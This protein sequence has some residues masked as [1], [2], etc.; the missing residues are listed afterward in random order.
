MALMLL[1]TGV[2]LAGIVHSGFNRQMDPKGC[3]MTFMQPSYYRLLGLGPEQTKLASKYSLLLYR[4]EYDY[5]PRVEHGQLI[6]TCDHEWSI[7]KD[8]KL[9]PTG[10]PALFIPGNA[11][12]AKQVRSMAKEASKYYYQ[13]LRGGNL[14]SVKPID[15]NEEFTAFHGKS[16]WD[17]A[18]YVNEAIAYILSLYSED[19][20]DS[21]R[22][23]SI[24]LIGHSMGGIVARTI[25]TLDNFQH[26]SV[27]TIV[28][29]ATPHAVPPVALD[30]ETTHIYDTIT[31]FW[32]RGY[33]GEGAMLRNVTLV[34]I[35]GGTLDTTVN[36]DSANIHSIIPQSHGFTVFTSNIPHVWVGCDH[37]SILWCNQVASAIGQTL[38][39]VAEA[40]YSGKSAS[41]AERMA[42][43]RRRLLTGAEKKKSEGYDTLTALTDHG[44]GEQSRLDLLLCKDTAEENPKRKT[45]FCSSGDLPI[46]PVPASTDTSSMPLFTGECFTAREFRSMSLSLAKVQDYQFLAI[47]DRGRRF[48]DAGFLIAQ[49]VNMSMT[50]KTVETSM[51]DHLTTGIRVNLSTL[52]SLTST[53]RLPNIDN[54]LF[55]YTLSV[56]KKQCR[57]QGKR[58]I[59]LHF[60]TDPSCPEPLSLDLHVDV[61]GSLGRVLIR[62]RMVVLVFTYMVVVLTVQSQFWNW[63]QDGTFQSFGITLRRLITSPRS[64]KMSSALAVMAFIQ[65]LQPKANIDLGSGNQ[66][67]AD[68]W[69]SWTSDWRN[70]ILRDVPLGRNATFFWFLAPLFFQMAV[71]I[72]VLIWLVLNTLVKLLAG[73]LALTMRSCRAK[74]SGVLTPKRSVKSMVVSI[75]VQFAFVAIELPHHLAFVAIVVRIL[76]LCAK[77]LNIAKGLSTSSSGTHSQRVASWNRFHYMSSVLVL[78]FILVPFAVP[79]IMALARNFL[80]QWHE[81]FSA[82][83]LVYHVA[84]FMILV[85]NLARGATISASRRLST[86]SLLT[87]QLF[88]LANPPNKRLNFNFVS[89]SQPKLESESEATS[90]S[91]IF[92]EPGLLQPRP[93]APPADDSA[94]IKFHQSSSSF[95]FQGDKAIGYYPQQQ[96]H[97]HQHQQFPRTINQFLHQLHPINLSTKYGH[98]EESQPRKPL[99]SIAGS[100]RCLWP[101]DSAFWAITGSLVDE[102][103]SKLGSQQGSNYES[104]SDAPHKASNKNHERSD[105]FKDAAECIQALQPRLKARRILDAPTFKEKNHSMVSGHVRKLIQEAVEDG[106]GELDLSYLDLDDLPGEIKDLNYAIV[107]NERGSFSL[108]K[109][110]LKLFLSSNL[111]ST[112]PMDV[113]S[114]HNLYPSS[115]F[116]QS[117]HL[118]SPA[119]PTTETIGIGDDVEMATA[120]YGIES[121]TQT[122]QEEA[123]LTIEKRGRDDVDRTRNDSKSAMDHANLQ[124]TAASSYPRSKSPQ[125]RQYSQLSSSTRKRYVFKEDTIKS[126]LTPYLYDIFKRAR[127]NNKCPGCHDLFW[128]PCRIL[129]VWQDILG[130]IQVPIEWKGCGIGK[131]SGIPLNLMIP[132]SESREGQS[133]QTTAS[134]S[135]TSL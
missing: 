38:V 70:D 115:P 62:Y 57:G 29:V 126:C 130:Q 93:K 105:S 4:D 125:H 55:A 63:N 74:E 78:L 86:S 66:Q 51:L 35:M 28:T 79:G 102:R 131:C 61:Y 107:Y 19:D 118:S 21:T 9:R 58:G 135:S 31:S 119:S 90:K 49:P 123:T 84:P 17:Q 100:S 122:K 65:S 16:L 47:L 112:I 10:V 37:L 36:G 22:P 104:I 99:T 14:D 25:F 89:P 8:A 18:R 124:P 88:E 32:T 6:Q 101:P 3:I 69:P 116:A 15:F 67:E 43:F 117:L 120:S 134:H 114:L 59:E 52:P 110:R 76:F 34:S 128:K 77:E 41:V 87:E 13:T 53:L 54:S 129:I 108:S 127:V 85:E 103:R 27:D 20:G 68:T 91:A 133:S 7:D 132:E 92:S 81:P 33:S 109:N 42:I 82:D 48:S 2:L 64:W 97:Q 12:S 96:Q 111:F 95:L 45:L 98:L 5:L 23:T 56:G 121:S 26:G 83:H 46:F 24:L 71:G 94:H 60:W 39:Q 40:H 30:Y 106:V 73:A 1:V 80:V 75:F 44:L 113:F 72:T 11:G 50:I